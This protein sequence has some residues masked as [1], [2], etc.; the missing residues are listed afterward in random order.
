MFSK[1][2]LQIG[3]VNP[4]DPVRLTLKNQKII[5]QINVRSGQFNYRPVNNLMICGSDHFFFNFDQLLA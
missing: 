2:E 3:L 5:A 1:L 4:D